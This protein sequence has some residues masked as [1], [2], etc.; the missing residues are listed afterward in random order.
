[1]TEK[2]DDRKQNIIPRSQVEPPKSLKDR[3]PLEQNIQNVKRWLK[4]EKK[5]KSRGLLQKPY[6]KWY[7]TTFAKVIFVSVV[8]LGCLMQLV[9]WLKNRSLGYEKKYKAQQV[10]RAER[11]KKSRAE[12]GM[13]FRV[14]KRSTKVPK[15]P[16]KS[17]S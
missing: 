7:Q 9:N 13:A 2:S 8:S 11:Q 3:T 4:E 14:G 17:Y 10:R 15:I 12:R 5:R 6:T 16:L 1:M